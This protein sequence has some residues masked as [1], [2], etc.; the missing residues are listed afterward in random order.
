MR[1]LFALF[2]T[3]SS[4][5]AA[6]PASGPARFDSSTPVVGDEAVHEC[7]RQFGV[8]LVPVNEPY[9]L[10]RDSFTPILGGVPDFY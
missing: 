1:P 2:L 7:F 10:Y 5:L 3:A 6:A 8:R 9:R 4:L